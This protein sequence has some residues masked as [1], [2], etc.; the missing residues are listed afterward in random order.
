MGYCNFSDPKRDVSD[1]LV[2]NVQTTGYG[3]KWLKIYNLAYA[4]ERTYKVNKQWSAKH[5]CKAG[6][7]IKVV[8]EDKPKWKKL[9]DGEFVKTGE[10]EV[11]IK[12]FKVVDV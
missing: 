10:T 2:L 8:L 3:T 12:A 7:V 6:D 4:A 9:D 1:Y 5:D 11:Q